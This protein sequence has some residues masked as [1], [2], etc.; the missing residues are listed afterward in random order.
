MVS[1]FLGAL[2]CHRAL[3]GAT[4][5]WRLT[6]R[7]YSTSWTES[8]LFFLT[9][10]GVVVVIHL[11]WHTR[12]MN[13][14]HPRRVTTKTTMV[15]AG[16]NPHNLPCISPLALH[17]RR[18]RI[19]P[20]YVARC[21]VPLSMEADAWGVDTSRDETWALKTYQ[22][23]CPIFVKFEIG[24]PCLTSRDSLLGRPKNLVYVFLA[25]W[26]CVWCPK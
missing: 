2:T 17:S 6:L 18:L 7:M 1:L 9:P 16:C 24:I 11:R 23:T 20:V 8:H 12:G 26:L 3:M 4:R 14:W 19:I 22:Y 25:A 21:Q 5:Y 15:N 10:H 13:L